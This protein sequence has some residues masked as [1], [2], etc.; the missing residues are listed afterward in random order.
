MFFTSLPKKLQSISVSLRLD[1]L[2]LVYQ[3]GGHI[4]GSLS[5]LDILIALYFGKI[6]NFPKTYNFTKDCFILSAG[7]LAPA[8]YT[9]LAQYGT[10]PKAELTRYGHFGSILQGHVSTDVPGVLF[11]SG[12]LG[13]GLSFGVGLALADKKKS[14]VTLTSDGEH[15]EGQIW[16]A[17]MAASKYRLNN[18]INIVDYNKYQIDGSTQDIMPLDDLGSKYLRFGWSVYEF[19]GHDYKELLKFLQKAKSDALGP[20]CLIA[21]TT[22]GKG[23]S[24][25]HYDYH[26]HDV[27][28]LSFEDY[29]RAKQDIQSSI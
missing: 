17:A 20:T 24:Y 12:A 22:L 21:H 2:D 26:Y 7:H 5:S 28:T 18:L 6:F 16:E 23:I 11:S 13:Q 9:V 3:N 1:L 10:F 25:M 8:L 19:D 15:Q 29:Q 14:V 27:A 4:G